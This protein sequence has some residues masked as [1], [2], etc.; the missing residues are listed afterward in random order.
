[1]KRVPAR[2]FEETVDDMLAEGWTIDTREENRVVLIKRQY[3]SIIAHLVVL[4]F[5]VWFTF[6]IGNVLYFGYKYFLD[7]E[8]EVIRMESTGQTE[9]TVSQSIE[10][11]SKKSTEQPSTETIEQPST[12]TIEQPSTETIEPTD[13]EPTA[14][15]ELTQAIDQWPASNQPILRLA[16][17]LEAGDEI[18]INDE[19]NA[20]INHKSVFK[21][22]DL[23]E[24]QYVLS[25]PDGGDLPVS[26]C[27]NTNPDAD[28]NRLGDARAQPVVIQ[29]QDVGGGE[30][31]D[32]HEF[33]LLET[34]GV[35][36]FG[37]FYKVESL[38]TDSD[39]ATDESKR[40]DD[41][42]EGPSLF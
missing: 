33:E 42:E 1:M 19:I 22:E 31:G 5:T 10:Q 14:E 13:T 37:D 29:V 36:H 7:P 40:E 23:P 26:L 16:A 25:D 39:I 32:F 12:E 4:I 38:E 20:I 27:V 11:P 35:D 6:G 24:F 34:V 28:G 18:L 9:A 17:N 41:E 30:V 15:E 8:R 3:G 2:E 21:G